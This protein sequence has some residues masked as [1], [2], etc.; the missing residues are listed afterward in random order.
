MMSRFWTAFEMEMICVSEYYGFIR[1]DEH[2]EKILIIIFVLIKVFIFNMI[3]QPHKFDPL[4]F[5]KNAQPLYR[6]MHLFASIYYHI[7]RNAISEYVMERSTENHFQ[8]GNW[9]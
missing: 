8:F 4:N 5:K 2:S 9:L 1:I 3:L 7:S 6:N